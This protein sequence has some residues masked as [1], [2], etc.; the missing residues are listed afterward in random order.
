LIEINC[1]GA[2]LIFYSVICAARTQ[3]RALSAERKS[4]GKREKIKT[5]NAAFARKMKAQTRFQTKV[6]S[7]RLKI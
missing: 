6:L 3:L 5:K 7:W 4:D 2:P 1:R